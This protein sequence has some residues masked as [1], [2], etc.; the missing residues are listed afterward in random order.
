[1]ASTA[2]IIRCSAVSVPIVMSVPQKSLSIE[3]TMPAMFRY[4]VCCISV[5]LISPARGENDLNNLDLW[6]SEIS[7]KNIG[8]LFLF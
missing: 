2:S 7:I 1:M 4:I 5:S 3:P 6:V 8:K